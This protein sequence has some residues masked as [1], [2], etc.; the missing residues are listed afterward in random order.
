MK[1]FYGMSIVSMMMGSALA[2]SACAPGPGAV[3]PAPTPANAYAGLTCNEARAENVR[4]TA[5]VETLSDK[6]KSAAVGDAI[7]V[8]LVLVPV[9]T[10]T[11]GNVQGDLATAKGQKLAID[12]R[13]TAC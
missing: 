12:A 3:A 11:G 1:N 10:L 6:Q 4:L 2:L 8:F 13:L 5:E 9:S 7:G